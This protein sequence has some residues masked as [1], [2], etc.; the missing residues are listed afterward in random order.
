MSDKDTFTQIYTENHWGSKESRSGEGSEFLVTKDVREQL[1]VLFQKYDIKSVLD[2]GCGDFNWMRSIVGSLDRY[3]GV[4]I[5]Q[6]LVD[7]NNL[8]FKTD[9]IEFSCVNII[10]KDWTFFSGYDA[11]IM[12]DVLVHQSLDSIQIIL[13]NVKLGK[14]KFFFSTSFLGCGKNFDIKNGMWRP[15]SLLIPPFN[16]PQP[17]DT[18][19]SYGEK[20]IIDGLTMYDKTLSM[21]LIQDLTTGKHSSYV[22]DHV[23]TQLTRIKP[24]SVVDVGTGD[25]FWGKVVKTI[26]KDCYVTGVELSS[27]WYD[28]SVSLKVYDR[29]INDDM[30][31]ITTLQGDVIIFGDVLEHVEK[32]TAMTLIFHAVRN[33]KYV[34]IN[35][36]TGFQPQEHEDELEIHRCGLVLGDFNPYKVLE[37][38]ESVASEGEYSVFNCLIEGNYGK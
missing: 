1:P 12:R 14:I 17:L 25:G 22:N 33:F 37:Y 3:M 9:K 29:M 24:K 2:I 23:Y 27:K 19:I 20:Y 11:V 4:D 28:H 15:I 38:H 21:F 6:E 31:I 18:I 34:I 5:V 30:M 26:N 35:T 10:K 8:L 32:N 13:R 16:M 36:P 7:R